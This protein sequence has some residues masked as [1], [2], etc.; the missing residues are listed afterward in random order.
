YKN[1]KKFKAATPIAVNP[2][3]TKNVTIKLKP[4]AVIK[5]KVT[6]SN[7]QPITL[8]CEIR[9]YDDDGQYVKSVQADESGQ[10]AIQGLETGRYKL[11]ADVYG[12]P[13]EG[14]PQPASEWYNGKC[15][16]RDAEFV[17]VTAPAT[18]SNI[19]FTLSLGGYITCRV[20][21]S[22]G[23]PLDYEATVYAYNSR[24][25]LVSYADFANYDGRFAINGLPSGNFRVRAVYYG[26]E[27]YLSEFYDNKRYFEVAEDIAVTAPGGTGD[28]FF[29]LDYAGI[30]QGYLTDEKKNRV[31]DEENHLVEIYAFDAETGEFAGLTHNTFMSGYHLELLEGQYKLA[32]LSF[33]YN[34]M[35]GADDLGVAYHPNGKKFNDPATKIYS[36]K[37]GSAKKLTS[38][39]LD[40]PK[41]S[42][43]GTIYDD[44]SGL[45]VTQGY[46]LV[47]VF[48]DAG[49]LV[50]LSGYTDSN[51]PI[52]GEYRV[53]GLRPGNYYVLAIALNELSDIYNIPLEWYGGV[54]VAP[55][56]IYSYTPKMEIPAGAAP[57]SVGTGDTGGID[58]YL[59]I[60]VKK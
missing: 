9:A 46:Y 2:P 47:W 30:F 11:Y 8:G 57:V 18:I 38:L 36:A 31:I 15:S 21:D 35:A 39:A 6:G 10:F 13:Y 43:S 50:S 53:G 37:P 27:N 40:K 41:G 28:I 56:E 34:W 20:M 22:Y 52:S 48:D 26:D 12:Y 29:E 1:A 59:D 16:F 14:S 5:G 33:Y 45:P 55:D 49:Y 24:A 25:E 17:K 58:F 32:A 23:Y 60:E 42:I 3:Q 7:G 54:E 4:G 51:A 19:N 44:T